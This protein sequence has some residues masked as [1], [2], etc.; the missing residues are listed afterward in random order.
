MGSTTGRITPHNPIVAKVGDFGAFQPQPPADA[1]HQRRLVHVPSVVFG[2]A[3][4][5]NPFFHRAMVQ[6]SGDGDIQPKGLCN[7]DSKAVLNVE[8]LG[9][10]ALMVVIQAAIGKHA[11]NIQNKKLDASSK[12]RNLRVRHRARSIWRADASAAAQVAKAPS[13]SVHRTRRSPGPDAL[14]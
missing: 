4:L 10:V 5:A 8:A 9:D 13:C 12:A 1:L 6:A 11:G 7:F 2:D 14:P 3:E